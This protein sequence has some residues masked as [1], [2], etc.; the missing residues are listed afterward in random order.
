MTSA[1]LL[2]FMGKS[3]SGERELYFRN[4]TDKWSNKHSAKLVGEEF[5]KRVI[6]TKRDALVL[7][8]HPLA[9]KNR[10]LKAKFE[11]FCEVAK[12][13][14]CDLFLARYNGVNESEVFKNPKKLPALVLFKQSAETLEGD[15]STMKEQIHFD[16]TR[17]HMTKVSS[18][19]DFVKEMRDFLH[20]HS[21]MASEKK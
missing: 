19:E 6:E 11:H 1:G 8:F 14:G 18:K 21:Q 10:G 20:E 9:E 4:E 13:E 16:R 5:E 17:H 15:D 7:I 12:A 3:Q 2:D